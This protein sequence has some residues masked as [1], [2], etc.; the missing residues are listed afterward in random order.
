MA[1]AAVASLLGR[2]W[3]A[4]VIGVAATGCLVLGIPQLRLWY[5]IGYLAGASRASAATLQ[6]IATT[7]DP[8]AFTARV[9]DLID[10]RRPE[11]WNWNDPAPL[12]ASDER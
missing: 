1:V 4:A 12:P 2:D 10:A 8:E 9:V 3:P 7:D 6:A 5:R 11:P